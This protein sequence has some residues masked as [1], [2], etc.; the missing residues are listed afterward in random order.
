ME[1]GVEALVEADHVREAWS[2][3]QRWYQQA[4]GHP[5]P[6]TIKG[7]EHALTLRDD[8]Y[9]WRPLEVEAILIPVQPSRVGGNT[10]ERGDIV[11]IVCRL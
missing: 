3:I 11:V 7:L 1:A 2:N 5:T 6:P 8:I 9:R 4:N 10:P